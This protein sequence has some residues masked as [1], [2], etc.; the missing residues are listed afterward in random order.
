MGEGLIPNKDHGYNIHTKLSVASMFNII[1]T[2]AM[3]VFD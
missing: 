2:Y 3:C 1:L